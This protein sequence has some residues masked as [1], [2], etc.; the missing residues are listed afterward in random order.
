M[1]P[2]EEFRNTPIL[3]SHMRRIL[4]EPTLKM[5]LEALESDNP[6]V[7]E[8]PKG[9]QPHEAHIALGEAGGWMM[10][11][12][13]FRLGGTPIENPKPVGTQADQTYQPEHTESET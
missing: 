11:R 7:N 1:T 10:Y 12:K 13:N 9:S 2:T 3:V 5:W 4:E 6:V 8:W